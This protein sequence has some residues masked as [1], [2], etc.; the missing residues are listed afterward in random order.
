MVL[1]WFYILVLTS[2][3][4]DYAIGVESGH[5]WFTV[6][7]TTSTNGFKFYGNSTNIAT[8]KGNGDSS[9]NGSVSCSD[10]TIGSTNVLT[11]LNIVNTKSDV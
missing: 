1:N 6:G 3:I 7:G 10:L 2:T 9:C 8:I 11:V 5:A 4:A